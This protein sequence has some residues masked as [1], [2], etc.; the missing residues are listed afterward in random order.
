MLHEEWKRKKTAKSGNNQEPSSKVDFG[1][2]KK[3]EGDKSNYN[4]NIQCWTGL[5]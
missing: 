1:T 3:V 4:H 2:I 5:K